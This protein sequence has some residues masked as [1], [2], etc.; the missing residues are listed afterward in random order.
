[1]TEILEL[2]FLPYERLESSW[3][4]V[5]L[6]IRTFFVLME[7]IVSF[8]THDWSLGGPLGLLG[9]HLGSLGGHLEVT[10]GAIG[11]TW[12]SLGM[13]LGVT[14]GALGGYLAHLGITWGLF[15]VHRGC[16]AHFGGGK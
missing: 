6:G 14:W 12:R 16:L 1:M 2:N 5:R 8:Q 15:G 11:V 3:G 10:W 7:W 9:S 13:H 4:A